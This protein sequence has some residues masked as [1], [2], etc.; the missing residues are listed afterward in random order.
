MVAPIFMRNAEGTE[1]L[2]AG[3]QG[4]YRLG[5]MTIGGSSRHGSCQGAA[6]CC[7]RDK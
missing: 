6:R 3:G 2:L 5:G 4:Y 1:A 7:R